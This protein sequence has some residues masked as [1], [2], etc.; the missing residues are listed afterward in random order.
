METRGSISG[1][2]SSPG[3]LSGVLSSE[4]RVQG[5]LTIPATAGL[6]TYDGPFEFTPSEEAQTIQIEERISSADIIIAP[7][8]TNYG[9]ITQNGNILLIE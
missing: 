4:G 3:R 8:P 1:R 7:I 2:I 5:D 9:R 6:K